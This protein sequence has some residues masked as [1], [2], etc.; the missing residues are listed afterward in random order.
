[1]WWEAHRN[2]LNK[3][4][5]HL[6]GL[7]DSFS[8]TKV[9]FISDIHKRL[10]SQAL[11]AEVKEL[12][13]D[14]VIIGGDICERGVSLSKIKSNIQLLVEIGPT[15]FVWGNNDYEVDYRKLDILL[16]DNHVNV[17]DNTAT[18][19]ETESDTLVLIGV[20]DT[21]IGRARLDLAIKDAAKGFR[22]LVSHNPD[23]IDQV[24]PQHNIQLILSGHT[25]GGQIRLFG[26]GLR[27]KGGL[28]NRKGIPIF[29]SNGYG[30]TTLPLR[31]GAPSETNLFTLKNK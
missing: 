22:I 16:R 25:H 18:S 2:T 12:Q 17:L 31:L 3:I 24:E 8:G 28:K 11:L 26:W 15:Y 5:L 29:I 27:E 19:F 21:S 13:P 1:M 30:T 7:P 4:N 10:I 14:L 20:D 9:F 23:I 6:R